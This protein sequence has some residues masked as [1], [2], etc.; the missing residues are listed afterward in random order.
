[1]IEIA[2]LALGCIVIGF[3]IGWAARGSRST[4]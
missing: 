3:C 2:A 1:M 4:D